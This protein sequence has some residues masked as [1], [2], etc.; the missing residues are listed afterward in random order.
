MSF[1]WPQYLWWMLLLPLLPSLYL[2]LLRRRG[3]PVLRL[4]SIAVVRQAAG[5]AWRR[6]IPP[7][8]ILLAL[9][10][11]LLCLA[12]PV[13]RVT[14]PWSKAIIMLAIDV[15]L[16]MRVA[17]VKPTRMVAAQEAAR[18]F[19]QDLPPDIDVGIVTFAG[20]AVVAQQITR[21]R[22]SLKGAI[23]NIQMQ[24]G[25]AIG[26]AIVVCL[27]ELFPDHGIDLSDMIFGSQRPA[28]SLDRQQK[29]PPKTLEPVAPGS[30]KPAAIILLSDGR[31][32][33]GV[34]T[35]RAAQ[36]AADR[37]VRVHVVGL[38]TP[39][40]HLMAGEGMAFYLK[41]D[42]AALREV[43]RVTGGEYHQAAD[44]EALRKVYL[45]LG[46]QLQ[47]ETRE[48]EVSA[49]LAL[50]AALLVA[51]GTTLSLLWYGRVA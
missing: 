30:Y 18:S 28:Q 32:T 29:A 10:L 17:D 14:L 4:S 22:P 23:D 46:S 19:L 13:A 25:T 37:G 5:P 44:A 27:A 48:T 20:T 8:L 50:L 15:S 24:R 33:T 16:S 41:L 11:L 38:G 12:R 21:D 6:H 9:A 42:E 31:R 26:S 34:E 51:T 47:T 45:Q 43:A 39:D 3:K 36:M 40:G 1:L 49:L 35:L 2:W 7:A